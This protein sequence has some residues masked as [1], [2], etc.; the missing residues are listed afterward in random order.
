MNLQQRFGFRAD[1][2]YTAV[3]RQPIAVAQPHRLRQIE[4]QFSTALG[5][6]HDAPAE[7]L[8]EIQRHPVDRAAG[9]PLPR[10]PY[11]GGAHQ[12]RKYRCAIG[13]SAAGSQV[14]NTPSARTS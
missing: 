1:A 4:Q 9:V 11:L 13:S 10:A 5:V 14:S 6:Q 12:N 7:S 3:H 2:H 8:V